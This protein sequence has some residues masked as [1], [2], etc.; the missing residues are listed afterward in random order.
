MINHLKEFLFRQKL[1]KLVKKFRL[2]KRAQEFYKTPF[3]KKADKEKKK[4]IKD[5]I[6]PYDFVEFLEIRAAQYLKSMDYRSDYDT[7]L[8]RARLFETLAIQTELLQ[9]LKAEET[10]DKKAKEKED[11]II[12]R[13]LI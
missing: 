10:E 6:T 3:L 8:Q 13:K 11:R 2:N 7:Q 4:R 1:G 12:N 9:A 5:Y